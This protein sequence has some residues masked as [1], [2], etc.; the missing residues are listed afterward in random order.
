M[1]CLFFI[2]FK[3]IL[4]YTTLIGNTNCINVLNTVS[5]YYSV[6][7]RIDFYL[8]QN[9]QH[10]YDFKRKTNSQE[11]AITQMGYPLEKYKFHTEDKYTLGLE[12]IPYSKYGNRSIGKPILLLHGIFSS[13]YL[14][15]ISNKSLSKSFNKGFFLTLKTFI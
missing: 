11:E 9:V 5:I 15:T 1:P 3:L 2:L 13:S 14:F 10:L 12:R 8:D 6:R 4:L 7:I